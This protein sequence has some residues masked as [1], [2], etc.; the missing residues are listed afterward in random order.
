MS[1]F[2]VL[3]CLL[4]GEIFLSM[5]NEMW[6]YCWFS[7]FPVSLSWNF[8]W[9]RVLENLSTLN[10]SDSQMKG[11]NRGSREE[12]EN[13]WKVPPPTNTPHPGYENFSTCHC[14]A[15]CTVRG[16]DSLCCIYIFQIR[17]PQLD[18]CH[19]FV[20]E[21]LYV[22]HTGSSKNPCHL[23]RLPGFCFFCLNIWTKRVKFVYFLLKCN[24]PLIYILWYNFYPLYTIS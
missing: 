7:V 15:V 11:V 3:F 1:R 20:W 9:H 13:C 18:V 4:G 14:Q 12:N 6:S 16:T 23:M 21:S 17:V 8:K 24:M 22:S 10:S 2:F 19:P 5:S